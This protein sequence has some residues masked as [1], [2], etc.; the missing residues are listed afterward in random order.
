MT[1]LKYKNVSILLAMVSLV[2]LFNSC[3]DE[4]GSRKES[5]PVI[6]SASI[7]EN[8]TFG[9][10]VTLKA[11][12]TDPATVLSTLS[13]EI[14]ESGRIITSGDIPVSGSSAEVSY[15][16][17]VPLLSNQPDN[18][19]LK[20]LLTAKNVLKGISTKELTSVG[21][22]PVYS[23][24]Y[25]VTDD[26]TVIMLNPKSS[27]RNV[28][29][30]SDLLLENTFRFKIA[31]KLTDDNAIDYTGAVFGN[32]NG[33]IA[34]IDDR[35]ESAFVHA[36]SSD[37]TEM[38]SYNSLTFGVSVSGGKAGANDILLSAFSGD[39]IDAEAFNLLNI[40]L[41]NNKEYRLL[42]SLADAQIVYNLDFFERT[43]V[44]KIKFLGKTGDYTLYYNPVRKN[45]F[46]GMNNPSYPDYLLTCGSGI[47]YPT[48]VSNEEID[49]VYS[50]H[51]IAHSNWGFGI[52]QFILFR[53]ISTNVF[54]ATLY[55]D[56]S[57]GF[58]PFENNGWANEKQAG[59]L[60]F[61]GEPIISGD[62]DWMS[63][64]S[65]A[66]HYRF[67]IDLNAKT[68]KIEKITL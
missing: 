60:T 66:G 67:T 12:L 23:R 22:R 41:E 63:G 35:G 20:V 37:F 19:Q 65:V 27:D 21:K 46:L 32:V 10:S 43:A 16:I 25:L 42:G 26:N 30:A 53:A 13:Y 49:A 11:M 59:G 68:V 15:D 29:E 8:F 48:K 44:G 52:T 39:N 58:K 61:T 62:N 57:A 31:E 17:Y 36:S 45:V 40:K 47:G 3:D 28:F 18:A 54:Q 6:E 7:T 51:R 64:G 4:Y 34:M 1:P 55:V 14:Q 38:F 56:N 9:S 50:G 2:F 5:T 33:R 24:L